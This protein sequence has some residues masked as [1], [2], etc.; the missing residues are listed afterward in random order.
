MEEGKIWS[1]ALLTLHL[2]Y[3]TVLSLFIFITNLWP[4]L[5][6]LK[7]GALAHLFWSVPGIGHNDMEAV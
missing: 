2:H 4:K 1:K 7:L 6:S 5:I 3:S